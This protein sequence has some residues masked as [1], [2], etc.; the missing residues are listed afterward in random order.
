[1][2]VWL[3]ELVGEGIAA[4]YTRGSHVVATEWDGHGMDG[5]VIQAATIVQR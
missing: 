5:W 2:N 3:C 1:M 4:Q